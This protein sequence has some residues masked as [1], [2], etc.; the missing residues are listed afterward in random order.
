MARLLFSAGQGSI[1][2]RYRDSVRAPQDLS[3]CRATGPAFVVFS[4][5]GPGFGLGLSRQEKPVAVA[6][7][8]IDGR[9][10]P[11]RFHFW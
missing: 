11:R 4:V 7:G 3:L 5:H 6:T 10:L 2:C 8:Q 9:V 1:G